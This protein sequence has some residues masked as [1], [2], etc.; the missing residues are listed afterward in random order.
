MRVPAIFRRAYWQSRLSWRLGTLNGVSGPGQAPLGKDK[1]AAL[2]DIQELQFMC[3]IS[4]K[5]LNWKALVTDCLSLTLDECN[6]LIQV[7][8][9]KRQSELRCAFFKEWISIWIR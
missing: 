8:V 9:S 4:W 1:T 7:R 2:D 6:Q 3:R 5:K